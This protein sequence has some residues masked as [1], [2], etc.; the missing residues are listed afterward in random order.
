MKKIK[1]NIPFSE[2]VPKEAIQVI[3]LGFMS[4]YPD[5]G[6]CVLNNDNQDIT[7]EMLQGITPDTILVAKEYLREL[8]KG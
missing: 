8:R 6:V 4:M 2:D 7:K 1:L 5:A 3:I